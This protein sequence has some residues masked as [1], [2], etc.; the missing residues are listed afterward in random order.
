MEVLLTPF[1]ASSAPD[2]CRG[3]GVQY[4]VDWEGYGP[5]DRSWVPA[6][7]ILDTSPASSKS[8]TDATLTNLTNHRSSPSLPLR[9][10]TGD[11]L[12]AYG[13]PHCQTT[14]VRLA[15]K[16]E[17]IRTNHPVTQSPGSQSVAP[18][19][20]VSIRCKTSS[21]VYSNLHWYL[22]KPG[23]APKLLI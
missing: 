22:Q 12:F 8:F 10:P 20:T 6:R 5:E 2:A 3:R 23:E 16:Q 9:H 19:Q 18:G 17:F 7:H 1:T 15:P 4:L 13:K 11:H 14:P 21:N